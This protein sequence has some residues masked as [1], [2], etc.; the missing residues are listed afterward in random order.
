[1]QLDVNSSAFRFLTGLLAVTA[2]NLLYRAIAIPPEALWNPFTLTLTPY[3]EE[4]FAVLLA[5][6]PWR[7][8]LPWDQG[9]GGR[10]AWN[11]AKSLPVYFLSQYLSPQALFLV[12]T[13]IMVAALY[14]A[15]YVTTRSLR[16]A[17]ALG[18][19]AALSTFLNYSFVYGSLVRNYL[20]IAY[21]AFTAAAFVKYIGS[22]QGS[23]RAW[24]TSFYVG[25]FVVIMSGEWWL[26]LAIPLILGCAFA[27]V[28]STKTEQPLLGRRFRLIGL[29]VLG[30]VFAYLAVRLQFTS[31][32]TALGFE[33]EM[34]FTYPSL[35]IAFED[36][37]INY[38]T[39][40]FITLSG[41]L[42]SFL[43]FSP[44]YV[45]MGPEAIL[46]EQ[47]GY[48]A[49]FTNHVVF[50]HLTSWR[51]VAGMMFVGVMMLGWRWLREAW[52]S[53]RLE[54]LV[55]VFL[56]LIIMTGFAT[57]VPIKMRPMHLTAMLGYKTV[58]SSTALMVL[59]AWLVFRSRDWPISDALRNGFVALV[60]GS[61]LIAAF[62]RPATHEA[63]L[64]AVGLDSAGDPIAN[65][66]YRRLLSEENRR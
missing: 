13:T 11:P 58:I 1:M 32:Y 51:F 52:T 29:S 18:L 66:Q 35:L 9:G 7:L 21:L 56:L 20:L 19:I 25:L 14:W 61:V 23:H 27:G 16:F 40:L 37:V 45:A 36:M 46:A 26:N 65:W 6:E 41:V 39:Y 33:N 2:C 8:F 4:Q 38:M 12:L 48:H 54:T 31:Q 24:L 17:L 22:E 5:N 15:S 42:P 64:E 49:Q 44:S 62:T 53:R 50:S 30:A 60:M 28:W 3:G 59:L 63:G 34:V 47:N 10:I 55:P 43:T 57:Y